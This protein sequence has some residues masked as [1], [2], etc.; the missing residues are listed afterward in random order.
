MAKLWKLSLVFVALSV[1]AGACGNEGEDSGAQEQSVT[2]EAFD[3]YYEETTIALEPGAE[4]TITLQN[5]GGVAHSIDIPDLDFELE[6][7][8]GESA[9]STFTVPDEPGSLNFFCKFH[10]DDMTGAVTIGG[11]DQPVEEDVDTG[12]DDADAEVDV[13]PEEDAG[14]ETDATDY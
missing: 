5:G 4:A 3:N 13:E 6:A 11:F 14:A 2:V 8:S 9:T 12:G 10:P 7:Q 1:V